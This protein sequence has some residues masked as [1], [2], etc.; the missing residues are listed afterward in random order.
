MNDDSKRQ[1]RTQARAAAHKL[2][3]DAAWAAPPKSDP[4][5]RLR[6]L[7]QEARGERVFDE[8]TACADCVAARAES[9]DETVLCERHLAEAMGF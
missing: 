1:R 6:E 5:Q 7:D 8:A 2:R 4:M 3:N 9:G